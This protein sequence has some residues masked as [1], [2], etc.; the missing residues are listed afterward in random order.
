[1]NTVMESEQTAALPPEGATLRQRSVRGFAAMNSERQRAIASLGGT[2]AH[3][4]GH[5]HEF[6]SEEARR[7]G[8]IG[9]E[10]VARNREH[11]R[12]IGSNGGIARSRALELRRLA[13]N[14]KAAVRS[15]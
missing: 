11:M 13:L 2:V 3:Q 10:K 7:A 14:P 1:M 9:G 4:L 12:R 15:S 6:D 5:A 8:R